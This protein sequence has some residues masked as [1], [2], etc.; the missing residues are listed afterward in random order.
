MSLSLLFAPLRN[1]RLALGIAVILLLP[2]SFLN[3][4]ELAAVFS[5]LPKLSC[6]RPSGSLR[7]L[8]KPCPVHAAAVYNQKMFFPVVMVWKPVL[9]EKL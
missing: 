6:V 4:C 2:Q 1:E 7:A 9:S 8:S 5:I 3:F